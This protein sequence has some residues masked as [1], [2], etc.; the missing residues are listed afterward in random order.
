MP[1][2]ILAGIVFMIIILV[3]SAILFGVLFGLISFV[4]SIR[5]FF[6]NK[7]SGHESRPWFKETKTELSIV[8]IIIFFVTITLKALDII[9][10]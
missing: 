4:D 9:R 2:N 1:E 5:R 10:I 7:I 8:F 6:I 3:F